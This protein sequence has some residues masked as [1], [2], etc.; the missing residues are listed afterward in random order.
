MLI[1]YCF[2]L[3]ILLVSLIML[4]IIVESESCS[5][6]ALWALSGSGFGIILVASLIG[7]LFSAKIGKVYRNEYDKIIQNIDTDKTRVIKEN[8][9]ITDIYITVNGQEYHFEFKEE[10]NNG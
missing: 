2:L 9:E 3:A 1:A 8:D 5:S 10:N 4:A 6:D 7:L